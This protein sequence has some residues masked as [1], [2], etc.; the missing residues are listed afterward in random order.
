MSNNQRATRWLKNKQA[1]AYVGISTWT[2]Q[3]WKADPTLR[4]PRSAIINNVEYNDLNLI[5]RWMAARRDGSKTKTR[6][7]AHLTK[8]RTA[9]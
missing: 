6:R 5:D 7:G 1:A 8:K 9:A 4:F 2:L 3:R